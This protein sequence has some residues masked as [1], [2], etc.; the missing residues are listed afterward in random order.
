M[1]VL[2]VLVAAFV[3]SRLLWVILSP[4]TASYWE[5]LYRWVAVQEILDGPVQPL[6]DYQADPYQGGSLLMILLG[7]P[8]VALGGGSLL[9]L[10]GVAIAWSAATLVA[11]H[12]LCRRFFGADVALAASLAYLA[13]PPLVAFWGVVV[14][15]FHA[16]STLF[17]LLQMVVFLGLLRGDWRRPAG[18]AA[19]GL[20]SGLGMWFSPTAGLGVLACALTWLLLERLPALRELAAA[21]AGLAAGLLPWLAYNVPRGFV[22]LG[23]VL[24][25]MTTGPDEPGAPGILAK[26]LEVFAQV[27]PVGLIDPSGRALPA[28]ALAL[29]SFGFSAPLAVA[30]AAGL[31]RA[32]RALGGGDES[33]RRE[34]VFHVYAVL[35]IA[36]YVASRLQVDPSLGAIGYRL[37][38]S[39]VVVLFVPASISLVRARRQARLR[40]PATAAAAVCL[41]SMAAATLAFALRPADDVAL[42]R[43][44]GYD[45]YGILAHRKHAPDLE[46]SLSAVRRIRDTEMQKRAMVGI[47]WE[48]EHRYESGGTLDEI[49]GRLRAVPAEERGHVLRGITWF[50]DVRAG[51]LEHEGTDPE[52]LARVRAL[53]AMARA[54]RARLSDSSDA[55]PPLLLVT[56]DTTRVD[57]LSAYGYPRGTTPGLAALAR[58]SVRYDRAWSTSAWTLPAHASLFTGLYPSSHGARFDSA[59]DAVLGTR[60]RMPIAQWVRA[61][62]LAP[63]HTTLAER[64]AAAGYRTGAFVA[65]PWLHRSFGLLQGFDTKDD[66]VSGFAGRPADE[67]TDRAT[68]WL[69]DLSSEPARPWFL[70][71][72]YFD[73]HAPY[74]PPP[75]YDDL[76]RAKDPVPD[77]DAVV[78]GTRPLTG[79][80]RQILV[81]R[82]D[83]EIRFMDHHLG[84]LLRAVR[85]APGGERALIVVTADHGEAFGEGGRMG[86]TYWLGE[87]ILRVPLLVRHPDG[88]G[89]GTVSTAPVSLVDLLPLVSA[90]LGLPAP[91]DVDGVPPGE[92]RVAFAELSREPT[93][94]VRYGERLDRDLGA[95]IDWPFKLTRSSRGERTL[96]K[97]D[98]DPRER[99][100]DDARRARALAR[101]LDAHESELGRA[102]VQPAEV[103]PGLVEALRRLGYVE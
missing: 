87:E 64:L 66:A 101:E 96:V 78:A 2:P 51:E 69:E 9:A 30:W 46:R 92:R 15:G 63:E 22:G 13:G 42:T 27:L 31:G 54:E 71:V 75:G 61:G 40:G 35:F 74:A 72:N 60:V 82:Y 53:D 70:F 24:E 47:G 94:A 38:P 89:A 103:D 58:Q 1:I 90:E 23:R 95:V 5:E 100:V 57:H 14:M 81:D 26:T 29:L 99:P 43:E 77:V 36:V 28:S 21:A 59:G 25:V 86:H 93:A 65:G 17:V 98:A 97:L 39:L 7:L 80:E 56:L 84:R 41:A 67:V 50:S 33:D 4:E 3:A 102:R 85:A 68:A 52:R 83:G 45:A 10:K 37:F 8:A 88:R 6:L 55:R 20:A 73:P 32:I 19:F 62:A 11:L 44:R 18:W 48:I 16:E 34:L 12:A 91:E 49:E 76:P 79:D